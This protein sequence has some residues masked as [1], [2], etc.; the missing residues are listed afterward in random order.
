MDS[1]IEGQ[2]NRAIEEQ[3][4][5][6]MVKQAMLNQQMKNK[7]N[8][9]GWMKGMVDEICAPKVDWKDRLRKFFSAQVPTDFTWTKPNRRFVHMNI[10]LPGMT[11]EGIGEG[12]IFVDTSGSC[13]LDRPQF[14]SEIN[15]ILDDLKPERVHVVQCDAAVGD[16]RTYEQGDP[17]DLNVFG[18]GGSDFRPA[19]KA[20]ASSEITPVWAVCLTDGEIDF[21]IDAPPY[22]LLVVSTTKAPGPVWAETIYMNRD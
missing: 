18:G 11:K 17:I 19:F 20:V 1:P 15:S 12:V 6:I 4:V 21:P 13:Y 10:Y 16:I 9:P 3:D 14:W 2:A 5:Q 8:L 7:G 22:P